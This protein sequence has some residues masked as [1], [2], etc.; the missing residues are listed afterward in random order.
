[1][2]WGVQVMLQECCPRV[3]GYVFEVGLGGG[4]GRR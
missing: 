1:M 2:A 3:V 4:G